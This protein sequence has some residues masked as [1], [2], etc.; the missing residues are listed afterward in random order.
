MPVT[1]REL[2]IGYL[3]SIADAIRT[4]IGISASMTISEMIS[5]VNGMQGELISYPYD[6]IVDRTVESTGGP[7]TYIGSYVFN[8][9][10]N[11]SQVSF[12]NCTA[13]GYRAFGY[14]SNLTKMY[15]PNCKIID[16]EAFASCSNLRQAS[17][18][19]CT[20]ISN[21]A[22]YC[23][24]NLTQAYFPNCTLISAAAFANC[25]NLTELYLNQVS[26][27]TSIRSDAFGYGTLS[28]FV[29]S[30]LYTNFVL[31]YSSLSFSSMF[32]RM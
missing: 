1:N 8:S 25:T 32:V 30:S 10:Y 19:N 21:Q 23:C 20:T 24:S 6:N 4:K 13:I 31:A 15:F 9:C 14:C 16:F 17:F 12:P 26:S 7:T 22:F 18:P 5:T 11:L 2:M 3:S 28:I 29:P 27:V